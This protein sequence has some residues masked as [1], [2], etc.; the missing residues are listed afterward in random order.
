M[1]ESSPRPSLNCQV[2][3]FT[4]SLVISVLKELAFDRGFGPI[5]GK[6]L[7]TLGTLITY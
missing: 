4:L 7:G 1:C 3:V 2:F 6:S 5:S